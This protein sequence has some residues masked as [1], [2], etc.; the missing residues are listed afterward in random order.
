MEQA[1][2]PLEEPFGVERRRQPEHAQVEVVANLVEERAQERPERDDAGVARRAHPD[3]DV[4]AAAHV[5]RVQAV[6]LAAG[7]RWPDL[8]HLDARRADA[9]RCADGAGEAPGCAL[10]GSAVVAL[11]TGPDGV[12]YGRELRCAVEAHR[13]DRV[14]RA[15]DRLL[16]A[17]ETLVVGEGHSSTLTAGRRFRG[18]PSR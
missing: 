17:R 12:H 5:E 16:R 14:A 11:E 10:Q 1:R 9:E 15:V 3:L 6:Q 2:F 18:H 8:E 13:G 7:E 4:G